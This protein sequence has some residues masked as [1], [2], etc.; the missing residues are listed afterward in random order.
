MLQPISVTRI[1]SILY[2][3]MAQLYII[4]IIII[5]SIRHNCTLI[6]L[7]LFYSFSAYIE[8]LWKMFTFTWCIPSDDTFLGSWLNSSPTVII[9][10]HLFK[11]I[12]LYSVDRNLCCEPSIFGIFFSEEKEWIFFKYVYIQHDSWLIKVSV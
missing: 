3:Y 12:W 8:R 10:S 4:I 6:L 1:V 7:L 2:P 11:L 5:I 9:Y